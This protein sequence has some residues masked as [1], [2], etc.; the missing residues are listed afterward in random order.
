MALN[1]KAI[2]I[3]TPGQWE[4]EYLARWNAKNHNFLFVHQNKIILEENIAQLAA[5]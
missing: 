3:P 2:L 1:K 4:Q 5:K